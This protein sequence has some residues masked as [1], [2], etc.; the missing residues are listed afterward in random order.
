MRI[1]CS[2]SPLGSSGA[3]GH[4]HKEGEL[5]AS[6]ML[7]AFEPEWQ[8]KMTLA[9]ET[10]EACD[11]ETF[12]PTGVVNDGKQCRKGWCHW[13]GFKVARCPLP[14]RDL[15]ISKCQPVPSLD[16]QHNN[17]LCLHMNGDRGT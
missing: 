10:A 13:P 5:V 6:E 11:C 2:G 12:H 14:C 3:G 8:A 17:S 4:Q 16:I 7:M 15:T 9:I 1:W